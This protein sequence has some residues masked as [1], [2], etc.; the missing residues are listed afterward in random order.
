MTD[1]ADTL[2]HHLHGALRR[3]G[4]LPPG[5]GRMTPAELARRVVARNGDE[6]MLRFVLDWYYPRRYGQQAGRMDDTEAVAYVEF[7]AGPL[8]IPE[9]P[10]DGDR[11]GDNLGASGRRGKARGKARGTPST[12]PPCAL[13]G[14]SSARK[15]R[16]G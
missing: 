3:Q 10:S 5:H 8:T 6:Q 16:H 9:I 1:L 15:T 7:I 14:G 11:R 4:A 2:W 13:C 12:A